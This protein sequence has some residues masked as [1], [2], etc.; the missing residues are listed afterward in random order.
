MKYFSIKSFF[1]KKNVLILTGSILLLLCL[2]TIAFQWYFNPARLPE[3]SDLKIRVRQVNKF[4]ENIS[5]ED[6]DRQDV[7][8]V[9]AKLDSDNAE[10]YYLMASL[11]IKGFRRYG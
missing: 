5:S 11:E 7:E 8:A 4:M 6:A 2:F 1:I 3:D 10:K 9:V